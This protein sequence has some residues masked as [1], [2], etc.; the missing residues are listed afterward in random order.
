MEIALTAL[1][2]AHPMGGFPV[3]A[4]FCRYCS[5][6]V[7]TRQKPLDCA[8]RIATHGHDNENKN[9]YDSDNDN[10]NNKDNDY[11]YDNDEMASPTN[12]ISFIALK[13]G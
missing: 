8:L 10:D 5:P 2:K 3:H 7:V 4:R 12:G 11:D 9:D 1:N 13:R 6:A